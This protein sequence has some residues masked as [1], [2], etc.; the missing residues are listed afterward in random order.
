[1]GLQV[2]L[3]FLLIILLCWLGLQVRV[4]ISID[5]ITMLVGLLW[6]TNKHELSCPEVS[7]V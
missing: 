6:P 7:A 4:G 3:G 1:M 2:E 5:I